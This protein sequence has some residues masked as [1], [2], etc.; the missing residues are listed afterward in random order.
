MKA[1]DKTE[2][3]LKSIHVLFSK[4]EP[5]EG[6]KKKVIIDKEKMLTLLK[7]LNDCMYSMM[8][9]YEITASAKEKAMRNVQKQSDEMVFDARKNAEDIYAASLMYTD[10]AI[11]KVRE[12]IDRSE[13]EMD[14]IHEQLKEQLRINNQAIKDN[15]L[16]L[17]NQLAGLID[18]QKYLML[19][20]NENKRLQREAERQ[21]E[22]ESEWSEEPAKKVVPEIIINE[23]YFRAAGL[24]ED[25]S[26]EEEI[27][28]ALSAELDAE[29]FD[30]QENNDS[31]S[32]DESSG[33][34]AEPKKWMFGLGR[35]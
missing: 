22:M 21:K 4:A 25:D 35:K 23:D 32:Q 13:E 7:R 3:V 12:L 9:E 6:S 34:E 11:D 28:P 30:W 17:K 14:R 5:I 20:E 26:K 24:I 33:E 16:E 1:K 19:I 10:H 15:Q 2:E 31:E 27:D 18:R 29:Y 8:E